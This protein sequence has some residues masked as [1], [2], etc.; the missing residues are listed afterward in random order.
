MCFLVYEKISNSLKKQ[1][2]TLE[3]ATKFSITDWSFELY[4]KDLISKSVKEKPTYSN[5]VHE[6]QAGLEQHTCFTSLEGH[7]ESFLAC[8]SVQGGPCKLAAGHLNRDW[9]FIKQE[10]HLKHIVLAKQSDGQVK[11]K[12]KEFYV[13]A[14]GDFEEDTVTTTTSYLQ[15]EEDQP[16]ED[17]RLKVS[18]CLLLMQI[19]E[20]KELP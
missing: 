20:P 2:A 17:A 9:Q 13:V 7:Y 15:S 3:K 11:T 6:L 1:F 8:L 4:T 12:T 5:I 10:F 18:L 14:E 19:E 16:H